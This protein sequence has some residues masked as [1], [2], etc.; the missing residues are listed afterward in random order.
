MNLIARIAEQFEDSARIQLAAIEELAAP[1]AM[2]AELMVGALM[3]NG[4]IL[5][6]G[7]GGSAADAQQFAATLLGRFERE[8]PELGA[9]ALN[10]NSSAITAMG[11]DYGY[12][13]IFAKQVRA[14]GQAGDIL[15]AISTSG[16]SANI[17]AAIESAQARDMRIIALTGKGGGE[18]GNQIENFIGPQDVHLCVPTERVA[19]IQ[20]IHRLCLNCLSD[21]IDCLLL[22]EDV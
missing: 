1:I 17:L 14:L 13:H 20:E 9:I 8:R 12:A 2:A 4:K 3:N 5:S 6:C 7:N 10:T 16:N 18:L 21:S 11:N 22:G 15:L 19:R